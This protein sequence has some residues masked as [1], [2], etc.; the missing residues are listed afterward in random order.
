MPEPYVECL[1]PKALPSGRWYMGKQSCIRCG[2]LITPG[3]DPAA[4]R[5]AQREADFEGIRA[6]RVRAKGGL[7]PEGPTSG[8]LHSERYTLED[9]KRDRRDVAPD[10]DPFT[11]ERDT[12]TPEVWQ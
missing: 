3:A 4:I 10:E 6:K 7:P 8:E 2:W 5:A 1:C 11:G 9:W 12:Y